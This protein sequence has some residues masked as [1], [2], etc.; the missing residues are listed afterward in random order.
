MSQDSVLLLRCRY[1]QQ[2]EVPMRPWSCLLLFLLLVSTPTT[3]VSASSRDAQA[4]SS[5]DT[6]DPALSALCPLNAP[7]AFVGGFDALQLKLRQDH[8]SAEMGTP[9]DCARLAA[10]GSGNLEQPSTT[11]LAYWH[12]ASNTYVFTDGYR[13][14]GMLGWHLVGDDLVDWAT[15]DAD[16]PF[17]NA[18]SV[19]QGA[20]VPPPG[21]WPFDGL[22]VTYRRV[23]DTTHGITYG[24]RYD[25]AVGTVGVGGSLGL[26][27]GHV[28][29]DT[30]ADGSAYCYEDFKYDTDHVVFR[31]ERF[32]GL[33]VGTSP[34]IASHGTV[35]DQKF[36]QHPFWLVSWLDGDRDMFQGIDMTGDIADALE[37]RGGPDTVAAARRL[38]DIAAQLVPYQR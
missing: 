36:G 31:I 5:V 7:Y 6:A 32:A 15:T 8:V 25:N 18:P 4:P 16:P 23:W 19:R 10:D 33:K 13:H 17:A 26:R 30:C 35:Y 27:S 34:A 38:T 21:L 9:T 20:L 29:L 22:K 3:L 14:W 37:A 28:P 11:G 2:I 12:R 1:W 24:H